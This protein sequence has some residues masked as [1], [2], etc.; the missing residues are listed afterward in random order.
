MVADDS[1][2]EAN[3]RQNRAVIEKLP[4]SI[5]DRVIHLD[6]DA[7]ARFSSSLQASTGCDER[8]LQVACGLSPR[9][10]ISYGANRNL[11]LLSSAGHGTFMCDD[12][13]VCDVGYLHD[14]STRGSL[15]PRS[16]SVGDWRFEFYSAM[17]DAEAAFVPSITATDVLQAHE[18]LLG[19]QVLWRQSTT[20]TVKELRLALTS[21]GV[22]GDC[23]ADWMGYLL[24][25]EDCALNPLALKPDLYEAVKENRIQACY[26]NSPSLIWEPRLTT[27]NVGIDNTSLIPPFFPT[28]IGEDGC[29]AQML[30][31][32]DPEAILCGLPEVIWHKPMDSLSRKR[33]DPQFLL[34]GPSLAMLVALL[35]ARSISAARIAE[36]QP[37]KRLAECSRRLRDISALPSAEFHDV[38][39]DAVLPV[40]QQLYSGLRRRTRDSGPWHEDAV[41]AFEVVRT[42]IE[43]PEYVLGAIKRLTADVQSELLTFSQLMESWPVLLESSSRNELLLELCA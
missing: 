36:H 35:L 41:S 24:L 32:V 40:L 9:P 34:E 18:E 3:E 15:S 42:M 7:K 11:L 29:F 27:I 6:R 38:I 30:R 26:V 43:R 4:P 37:R 16:L 23:G 12:D 17:G 19:T 22:I 13:V 31:L 20:D 21:M 1:G 2:S 10:G 39:I 28:G 5:A 14:L 25:L 8:V 33:F